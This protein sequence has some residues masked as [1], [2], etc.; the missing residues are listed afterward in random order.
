MMDTALSAAW[1]RGLTAPQIAVLIGG[2]TA[3]A[4]RYRRGAL[5]LPKR[6][7]ERAQAASVFGGR[8]K[9][10]PTTYQPRKP[11]PVLELGPESNPKPLVEREWGDCAF[12]VGEDDAGM[13]ICGGPV[14]TGARRPYCRHHAAL[15]VSKDAAHAA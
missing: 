11:P 5:G 9:A 15:T 7:G 10:T 4:V 13:L 6:E 1:H 12:P 8:H 2:V 3:S 14:P